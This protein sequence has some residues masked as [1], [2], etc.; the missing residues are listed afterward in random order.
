MENK[1]V[2]EGKTIAIVAYITFI[3][4]IIAFVM[5]NE[6]Q[7]DFARFHIRQSLGIIVLSMVTSAFFFIFGSL[8]SFPFLP[9]IIN[10]LLVILWVI[11]FI[12]AIQGEMKKVPLLGDQ[13]QDWF[14]GIG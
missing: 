2:E 10:F 9:T 8:F 14:K 13:F 5:N 7:N 12:G 6:K 4:L 11:G 3:G 1:T